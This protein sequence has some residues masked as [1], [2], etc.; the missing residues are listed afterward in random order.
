MGGMDGDQIA[1]LAYLGLLAAALGGWFFMQMRGNLS[2]SL[3]QMA[4]W[5]L[6]FLGVIAAYGLWNDIQRQVAPT[7]ILAAD[8]TLTLPVSPD[9]HY[10]LTAQVNGVAIPFVIDTGASEIVLSLSDAR[11]A[12]IDTDAL[13]FVGS[14]MTANG[15]VSTA[16]VF[17]DTVSL[18]G[19]PERGV[20]ATVNGGE[21]DVSLLGMSYLSRFARIEIVGGEM[22]LTR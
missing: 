3:Q 14:A 5:A 2:R 4:V 12:G 6:I 13:A 19:I 17:L 9:G 7:Q 18:G 21:M 8:G 20:A 15:P 1:R 22:I 11:A 10:Y 16:R